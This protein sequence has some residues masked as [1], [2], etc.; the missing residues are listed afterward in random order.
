MC[1]H[2]LE[3]RT[4]VYKLLEDLHDNHDSE[5]VTNLYWT[6]MKNKGSLKLLN[7]N[8]NSLI[9]KAISVAHKALHGKLCE[10][11][12]EDSMDRAVGTAA[13]LGEIN[14]DI[15]VVLAG[16]LQDVVSGLGNT[17]SEYDMLSQVFGPNVT[18]IALAHDKLPKYMARN[19]NYTTAQS[20]DKLQ[21]LVVQLED[22]RALYVR[23]A[24]RLHTMRVLRTLPLLDDLDRRQI[25]LEA[26]HVYAPLAHKMGLMR[27]H[28]DLEDLAFSVLEPRMFEQTRRAQRLAEKTYHD[29]VDMIHDFVRS[30]ELLSR[31]GVHVKITHRIKNKYQ[32]YLK[33]LRKGLQS[34]SEVRDILGLRLIV[35]LK[36]T[37]GDSEEIHTQ[38]KSELCYHVLHRLR[39]MGGW[40]LVC[41]GFKDYIRH[42]KANG[43][44]SLH[45]Y[46]C[47]EARGTPVEVQVRTRE[48]HIQAELGE[49][50]HWWYK[51][52][53]YRP[54]VADSKVYKCAWRSK[55]QLS[56]RSAAELFRMAKSQLTRSRVFV[57]LED[58]STVIGLQKGATAL[59]ALFA[60][61]VMHGLQ[62]SAVRINNHVVPMNHAVSTGDVVSVASWEDD[63]QSVC[64]D[65]LQQVRTSFAMS[66]LRRHFVQQEQ[67]KFMCM[68]LIKL[69]MSYELNARGRN[70]TFAS[71][72]QL[73]ARVQ[74]TTDQTIGNFLFTLGFA[75]NDCTRLLSGLFRTDASQI[76]SVPFETAKMWV[77]MQGSCGAAGWEDQHMLQNVVLPLLRRILPR[78]HVQQRGGG[79]DIAALSDPGAEC[80]SNKSVEA[81]WCELVG[82]LSLSTSPL[83]LDPGV[84]PTVAKK[85]LAVGQVFSKVASK[86]L[87]R[88]CLKPRDKDF[89]HAQLMQRRLFQ[90]EALSEP[91]SVQ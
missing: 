57:Y 38:R 12:L 83:P 13:V 35:D 37:R 43:Y 71:A 21:L 48:M 2:G 77:Q 40:A 17:S 65:K 46:I 10:R 26:R 50:A 86:S 59:D 24:E 9:K 87:L 5:S 70:I 53:T 80:A 22:Y 74:Q 84:S 4:S 49:A 44:Q 14:V 1:D 58:R 29:A 45:Q 18:K 20:E 11:S 60:I 88:E 30:D 42:P 15:S 75:T 31:E 28:D 8:E 32:I 54:E 72:D 3:T 79:G 52:F 91:C 19:S 73:C 25:A 89:S 63:A 36:R 23:L 34:L 82:H 47:C 69:L 27:V 90:P 67:N 33:L 56:V 55:Q 6:K 76:I 41:G 78:Q 62:A 16:L 39:D 61:H 68:G 51:D 81:C 7:Q 85:M 64:P 66:A